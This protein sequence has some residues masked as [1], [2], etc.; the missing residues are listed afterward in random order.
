MLTFGPGN[1]ENPRSFM[2]IYEGDKVI[3]D[4]VVCRNP[5]G[6]IGVYDRVSEK[7]LPFDNCVEIQIGDYTHVFTPEEAKKWLE[8][9]Y[10]I[11]N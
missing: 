4:F 5:E 1:T 8:S 6:V 2:T 11:I 7:F 10:M 3:R 9:P